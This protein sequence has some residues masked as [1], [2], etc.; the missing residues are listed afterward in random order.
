MIFRAKL[1]ITIA[2]SA[3]LLWA[4]VSGVSASAPVTG[5]QG[6]PVPVPMAQATVT[7]VPLPTSVPLPTAVSA[8]LSGT[9]PTP[10]LFPTPVSTTGGLWDQVFNQR[11]T[12]FCEPG[13]LASWCWDDG[14]LLEYVGPLTV[15]EYVSGTDPI[16]A[17]DPLSIVA[18]LYDGD[19]SCNDGG[20]IT[21]ALVVGTGC[22]QWQRVRTSQ[23]NDILTI[24]GYDHVPGSYAVTLSND[25]GGS[26]L[27]WN[28]W[29]AGGGYG[30][31]A[32]PQT[33]AGW[34]SNAP[35]VVSATGVFTTGHPGY[36][37]WVKSTATFY[38]LVFRQGVSSLDGY[39]C[40]GDAHPDVE[41]EE[42]DEDDVILGSLFH[43]ESNC[44]LT[45]TAYVGMRMWWKDWR[46]RPEFKKGE[47]PLIFDL[48]PLLSDP[49]PIS[50]TWGV[51]Q[52]A[53]PDDGWFLTYWWDHDDMLSG[54][55]L[56]LGEEETYEY[57]WI[58]WPKWVCADED[59]EELDPEGSVLGDRDW[60]RAIDRFIGIEDGEA[61]CQTIPASKIADF[62]LLVKGVAVWLVSFIPG[63]LGEAL[64]AFMM[65]LPVPAADDYELCA[66]SRTVTLKGDLAVVNPYLLALYWAGAALFVYVVVTKE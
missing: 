6:G 29:G 57:P 13:N 36:P 32:P 45:D 14:S 64:D 34:Y 16:T 59:F 54:V 43:V 66:F 55:D 33:S 23:F 17:T 8:G 63:E 28:I 2:L 53:Q 22:Y 24:C 41:G 3:V 11:A 15:T 5:T 39:V 48:L 56:T 12:V 52:G 44:P 35:A 62:L 25:D 30:A 20:V 40:L 7:P 31:Y 60:Q 49:A 51:T 27:S 65:G 61:L 18:R 37:T 9:L 50:H 46:L 26:S 1:A 10:M 38:S 58:R 21:N 4:F 19:V 47:D 42:E